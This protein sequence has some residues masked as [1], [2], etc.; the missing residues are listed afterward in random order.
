MWLYTSF[1]SFSLALTD[2]VIGSVG[3]GDILND[4]QEMLVMIVTTVFFVIHILIKEA[5]VAKNPD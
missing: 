4:V 2:V 3:L 1:A 5:Q